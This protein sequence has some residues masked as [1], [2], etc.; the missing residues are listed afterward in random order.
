MLAFQLGTSDQTRSASNAKPGIKA[1]AGGNAGAALDVNAATEKFAASDDGKNSNASVPSKAD[2]PAAAL[3]AEVSN[4]PQS[5]DGAD[6]AI[7]AREARAVRPPH[8]SVPADSDFDWHAIVEQMRLEGMVRELARNANLANFA[9]KFLELV[10]E[11]QHENLK[12]ERLVSGLEQALA[13]QAG[14][15]VQIRVT[16]AD[17]EAV[18][19][20]AKRLSEEERQRQREAEAIIAEDP[21]VQALQNEF[22][23]T[24]ESVSP[25]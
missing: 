1:S 3:S 14:L 23:A 8:I 13:E 4:E 19:T 21:T 11:P 10:V 12:A 25:R 2:I 15:E 16:V 24:I 9:G 22:G 6:Q 5:L 20:I 18:D 7:D 17:G